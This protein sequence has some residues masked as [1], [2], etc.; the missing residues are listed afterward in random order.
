MK[1]FL[2]SILLILFMSSPLFGQSD[3]EKRFALRTAL[4]VNAL[5]NNLDKRNAVGFHFGQIPPTKI[6]SRVIYLV[7]CLFKHIDF[8]KLN[9]WRRERDSNPRYTFAYGTLAMYWFKP[10]TH[11]SGRNRSCT[12]SDILKLYR[13]NKVLFYS[14]IHFVL[15]SRYL[16]SFSLKISTFFNFKNYFLL[17]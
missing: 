10:L 1:N 8:L 16:A 9:K 2:I 6:N 14:H 17:K 11:P 4:V 12:N 3:D 15:I 5:T 7:E 13:H